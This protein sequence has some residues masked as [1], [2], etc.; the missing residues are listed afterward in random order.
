MYKATDVKK[1]YHRKVRLSA[2]FAEGQ[3]INTTKYMEIDIF[4][5]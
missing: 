2:K 4:D 1:V 3:K 5:E